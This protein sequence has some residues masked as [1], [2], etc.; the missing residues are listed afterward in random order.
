MIDTKESWAM[1]NDGEDDL[2]LYSFGEL[3]EDPVEES[4]DIIAMDDDNEEHPPENSTDLKCPVC[5]SWV[6]E[7]T[8]LRNHMKEHYSNE[9][10]FIYSL[11]FFSYN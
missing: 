6:P 7:S 10:I 5:K 8:H 3:I 4:L 2:G 1:D 9:V 11:V